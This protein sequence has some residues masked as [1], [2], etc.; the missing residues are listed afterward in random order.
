VAGLAGGQVFFRSD[1][2]EGGAGRR[3]PDGAQRM[4]GRLGSVTQ[5]VVEA[6]RGRACRSGCR[7]MPRWVGR[8]AGEVALGADRCIRGIRGGVGGARGVVPWL[9]RVRGRD[10]MAGRAGLGGPIRG[11]QPRSE[12]R[13]VAS[14]AGGQSA[15]R[16][17]L[18]QLCPETVAARQG[19]VG[20][21]VVVASGREAG[22]LAEGPAR[23][24]GAMADLA[25]VEPG[26]RAARMAR[27][28]AR[29]MDPTVAGPGIGSVGLAVTDNRAGLGCG[30]EAAAG[31]DDG[32]RRHA[33]H[34]RGAQVRQV[35]ERPAAPV[36]HVVA[37]GAEQ[38]GRRVHVQRVEPGVDAVALG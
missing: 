21:G 28:P 2:M 3:G 7:G 35:T 5:G 11:G 26:Q 9:R 30:A 25:G 37:L 27:D 15:A 8:C 38:L 10:P 22:G 34:G 13:P 1:A 33:F 23:Q 31:Q 17:A 24:L 18:A 6:A 19:I 14:L 29:G 20:L 4:G 16:G 36:R 12:I 32:L